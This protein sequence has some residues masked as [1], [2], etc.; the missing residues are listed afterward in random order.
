MT[1]PAIGL[2][3]GGGA[4]RGLAHIGVLDRLYHARIPIDMIAGTSA[5]AVIGA[6]YAAGMKPAEMRR[7]VLD[8]LR[9]QQFGSLVD[10]SLPRSGLITGKKLTKTLREIF[11]GD[12]GFK[13]LKR[14]FACVAVDI[15]SG[16]E[17]VMREGSVL[18]AVRASISIPGIFVPAQRDG[19]YLVD[20]GILNHLPV[21]VA[22]HIGAD[23]VIAVN[24]FPKR[25]PRSTLEQSGTLPDT[26]AQSLIKVILQSIYIA[27]RDRLEQS[28]KQADVVIHPEVS[29]LGA[30]DF[31]Q[32]KEFIIQ[33]EFAADKAIPDLKAQL[34]KTRNLAVLQRNRTP[35]AGR[36]NQR[37]VAE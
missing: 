37:H 32:V 10:V 22:R 1:S 11:G 4:A 26:V 8:R 36:P 16:E 15:D 13:D 23:F 21:D 19:R 28:E 14:P 20:G 33:G 29:Y 25:I 30:E 31:G 6:L 18:E 34:G 17:V 27:A 5:G 35:D 12:I 9:W 2:A 24:V 3:L 7:I